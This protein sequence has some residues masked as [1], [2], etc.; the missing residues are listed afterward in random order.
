MGV[1]G[2]CE[3]AWCV[4]VC[5]SLDKICC[6]EWQIVTTYRSSK[7][8][9][10]GW[11]NESWWCGREWCECCIAHGQNIS[12]VVGIGWQAVGGAVRCSTGPCIFA[13]AVT[14]RED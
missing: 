1:R 13:K 4:A 5:W 3:S 2:A 6:G 9:A 11:M 14:L 10:E 12:G 8:G 7:I